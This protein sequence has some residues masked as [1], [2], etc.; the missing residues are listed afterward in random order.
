MAIIMTKQ[1]RPLDDSEIDEILQASESDFSDSELDYSDPEGDSSDEEKV[2]DAPPTS[3]ELSWKTTDPQNSV[4]IVSVPS[5]G[6]KHC[7]ISFDN[8]SPYKC[9]E[10]FSKCDS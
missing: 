6:G 7:V 10:V 9:F 3:N 4:P 8:L 1:K 5:F 2:A